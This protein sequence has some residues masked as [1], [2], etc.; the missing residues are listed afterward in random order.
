VNPNV[1]LEVP[2]QLRDLA[3]RNVEQARAAYGQFMD[4]MERATSI[5]LGALPPIEA[6]SG[7]KVVQERAVRFAKQNAEACF[8]MASEL[9]SAKDIPD[10]F[11]IQIRF[12]QYQMQAY[13]LQS[14]ELGRLMVEA[15]QSMQPRL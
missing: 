10:I 1:P 8:T 4:A 15:A 6:M 14:Q 9:A 11:A 7:F 5:W 13:A 2:Q 3:E 12:A